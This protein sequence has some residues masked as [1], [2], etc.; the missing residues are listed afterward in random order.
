MAASPALQQRLSRF[1]TLKPLLPK[2]GSGRRAGAAR[3]MANLAK[4]L[5][6]YGRGCRL[7]ISLRRAGTVRPWH[8]EVTPQAATLVTQAARQPDLHLTFDESV[9]LQIVAGDF[10]PLAAFVTGQVRVVGDCALARNLYRKLAKPGANPQD[11]ELT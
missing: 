2:T 6:S 3:S 10:A 4:A 11:F 7:Q 1:P 8:I 9:W 5:K